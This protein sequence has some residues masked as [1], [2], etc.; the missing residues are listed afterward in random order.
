MKLNFIPEK[1]IPKYGEDVYEKV[2]ELVG[3]KFK[4]QIKNSGIVFKE[5]LELTNLITSEKHFLLITNSTP[6]RFIDK[7]EFVQNFIVLLRRSI[8]KLNEDYQLLLAQQD[9]AIVDENLIFWENE[10]IGHY[11]SKQLA[12]LNKMRDFRTVLPSLN[13]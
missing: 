13:D 6:I 7:N 11:G 10:R 4:A 12:L 5:I 8:D 9:Q 1:M 2:S 3:L